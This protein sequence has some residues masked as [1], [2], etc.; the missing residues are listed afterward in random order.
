MAR[1]R[2]SVWF[3]PIVAGVIALAITLVGFL[4]LSTDT[5]IGFQQSASDGLFPGTGAN[6]RIVVIGIDDRSIALVGRWPWSR[7][8]HAEL[9]DILVADG[10]RVIGY[11]V[12]FGSPSREDPESDEILADS[13]AAAGN[14]VLAESVTFEG[15]PSDRLALLV[16]TEEF[17]PIPI[18]ADRAAAVG[19]VNT[20]PDP[21]NVVRALPPVVEGPDGALIPSLSF[22][23]ARQATGQT[24][25]ITIRPDAIQM[26]GI[27]VPTGGLH[28]LDLNF[29][30]GFLTIPAVEVLEGRVAPGTFEGRI[31]LVGATALGLGD[32]VET[33]L[34]RGELTA[35]VY[36]H[37][38]ALNTILNGAYL[39]AEPHSVT[40]VW[41]LSL[42]LL[43]GL[44]TLYW[45]PWLA[46]LALAA[47][48]V[49]FFAVVFSRFDSGTVMNMVYPPLAAPI[50]FVAGL[51][52][53][54]FTEVRER[55]YVTNVF[56]RYL[57][58]D[59]VDEVLT[60]PEGAVAT[61][62]GASRP[63]S[64]L[65][66]DLRGF[67][68]AS[69]KAAPTAVVEALNEYLDA[70]TKA[71]VEEKGTIDKFMGDCVMAFW[72]APRPDPD[73]VVRSVRAALKMLDYVDAAIASGRAGQLK[74]KG[75]GVGI[76]V[77]E[78]VVGNIGSNE[79]LD[80]TA[81]GDTVNTA[82]RV[83]GVA[84]G[85]EIVVTEEMAEALPPGEFKLAPLPP[86]K[87][88]GKTE[89]LRVFQVLREGQ[90]PK[91]F[92][93]G[94]ITDTTEEKGAFQATQ[95]APPKVAGYA[96]VEPRPLEGAVEAPTD[97]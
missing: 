5:F 72:G 33:P 73:Q 65:F 84:Q 10:A 2:R 55:K 68:A 59:V 46:V 94:A 11:D 80:Y 24:G 75:C 22:A 30:E 6:S 81:I 52:V 69:E 93:E 71:V 26:G 85:G 97:G 74:V 57:A 62:S 47:L 56:G 91:V 48:V 25:P 83:C 50:A 8:T 70:M 3:K 35:G 67:T 64:V 45:R 78:A 38:N 31:V 18:L 60:S 40:L 14:V 19:H 88:K 28:L 36:V 92:E 87:V 13:I 90:E 1:S 95:E 20:H 39:D 76:S 9:I 23:L 51:G 42:A 27:L 34:A 16:A 54:Y 86:L 66:A 15:R 61:L 82:S 96:P 77:G 63:L 89:V 7:A 37:A 12:T 49:G 17:P 4:G 21:D 58:K 32:L 43:I 44:A 79:R 29:A 41:V 53:R